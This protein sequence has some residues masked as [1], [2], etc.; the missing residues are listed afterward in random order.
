[1]QY[2]FYFDAGRCI[3]CNSCVVA[4]KDWNDTSPGGEIFWRRVTTVETGECPNV[5][6][7]N[8]SRSCMHCG[9]PACEAVCPSGAITKRLDKGI[10]LV[11]SEKC[12]GCRSCSKACP[13]GV[14]QYGA[15]GKMQKCNLCLDK[16]KQGKVPACAAACTGEALFA[17]VLQELMQ[18][19]ANKAPVR[20]AG[21]TQ[22][23]MLVPKAR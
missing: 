3:G 2:G 4:C 19:R 15:D 23:S 8:Q 11:D 21:A 20:L 18:L 7:S 9:K 17:G 10:V 22:P 13:F 5:R 16:V 1:M 14:P 12:I 6:L